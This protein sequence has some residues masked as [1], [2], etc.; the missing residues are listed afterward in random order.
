[1]LRGSRNALVD[2]DFYY[3]S[4]SV[5]SSVK[6]R[7]QYTSRGMRRTQKFRTVVSFIWISY[8]TTRYV[9]YG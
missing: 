3:L 8:V 5:G 1:M 7:Y 9:N 6:R 4:C 2:R